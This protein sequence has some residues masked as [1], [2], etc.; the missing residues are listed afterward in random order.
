MCLFCPVG[1][2]AGRLKLFCGGKEGAKD[3]GILLWVAGRL[4]PAG[5][6]SSSVQSITIRLS[7]SAGGIGGT[8]ICASSSALSSSSFLNCQS[9]LPCQA[10]GLGRKDC[11]AAWLFCMCASIAASV[12]KTKPQSRQ[13]KLLVS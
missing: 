7:V 4:L 8:S 13:R 11:P 12:V 6:L 5:T 1:K 9:G 3:W 2:K 10:G